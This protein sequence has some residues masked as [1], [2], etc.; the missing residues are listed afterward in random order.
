MNPKK[1]DRQQS[2]RDGAMPLQC[3]ASVNKK[4]RK[5]VGTVAPEQFNLAQIGEKWV[6]W[7]VMQV[8]KMMGRISHI[9]NI[10]SH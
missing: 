10:M 2:W 4:E 8:K 9:W 6:E 1:W 3:S 5:L 7:N